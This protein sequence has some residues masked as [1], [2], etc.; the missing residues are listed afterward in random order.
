MSGGDSE[1]EEKSAAPHDP[2]KPFYDKKNSFFDRISCEAIEKAKGN[3]GK[4]D[5]KK[6]WQTNQVS[7]YSLTFMESTLYAQ[8]FAIFRRSGEHVVLLVVKTSLRNR[9]LS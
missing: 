5:W 6:E 2:N 7:R 3:T 4:P 1:K 9:I 8:Y